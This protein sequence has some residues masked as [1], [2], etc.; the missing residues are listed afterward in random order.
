MKKFAVALAFLLASP[1]IWAGTQT[2]NFDDI[3]ATN[4]ALIPSLYHGFSFDSNSYVVNNDW[5]NSTYGNSVTFPSQPNVMFNASGVTTV[6]VGNGTPMMLSSI[7]AAWWAEN[8]SFTNGVSSATLTIEAFMGTTL[9]GTDTLTLGTNFALFNTNLPL[10][11]SWSFIN[12]GGQAWWLVDDATFTTGA[13][14]PS[15]PLLAGINLFGAVLIGLAW[16]ACKSR[17]CS[18]ACRTSM[19]V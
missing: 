14:E 19:A 2:L 13:P 16:K 1:C 10:A 18:S 6:S 4:T 9:V 8:N 11:N 3:S 5:Y 17:A 12:S 7:D 15:T